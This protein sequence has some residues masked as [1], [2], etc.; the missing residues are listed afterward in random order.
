MHNVVESTQFQDLEARKYL[1]LKDI[2]KKQ[3]EEAPG[4]KTKSEGAT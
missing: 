1:N 2:L 3:K 4:K